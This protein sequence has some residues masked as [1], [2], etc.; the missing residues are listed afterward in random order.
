LNERERRARLIGLTPF[1]DLLLSFSSLHY[2]CMSVCVS[3]KYKHVP[4][5]GGV[6]P[7]Y[8][9]A[10]VMCN[11]CDKEFD[12]TT[13]KRGAKG[14]YVDTNLPNCKHHTKESKKTTIHK[15]LRF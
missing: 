10:K 2:V 9:K 4:N 7:K 15:S 14:W 12:I 13:N 5:I 8:L 1:T 3:Y 6:M 11:T